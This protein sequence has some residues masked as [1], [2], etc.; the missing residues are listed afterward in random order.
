MNI[1]KETPISQRG[2][3][4]MPLFLFFILLQ[5]YVFSELESQEQ[6]QY[7]H[8]TM[9]QIET[10]TVHQMANNSNSNITIISNQTSSLDLDAKNFTMEG[11]AALYDYRYD[12]AINFYSKALGLEPNNTYALTGN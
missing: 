4:I 8:L 5:L 9:G 11:T 12:E 3:M 10:N 1:N 7:L 6:R 2:S